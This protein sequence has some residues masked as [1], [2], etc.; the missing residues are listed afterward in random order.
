MVMDLYGGLRLLG[1]ALLGMALMTVGCAQVKP[2][3]PPRV[4]EIPEGPGLFTGSQGALVLSREWGGDVAKAASDDASHI[5]PMDCDAMFK[6]AEQML[7][8][9]TALSTGD[10]AKRYAMAARAYEKCQKAG[11]DMN[12]AKDFFKEVFDTRGNM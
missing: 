8:A 10:K 11:K 2:F 9:N 6:E 5:A 3:D 4:G 1:V 12:E 7:A